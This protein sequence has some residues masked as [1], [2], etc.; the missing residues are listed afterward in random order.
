MKAKW[1]LWMVAVFIAALAL[2]CGCSSKEPAAAKPKAPDARQPVKAADASKPLPK[3]D[4]QTPATK[5]AEPAAKKPET[6]PLETEPPR[7]AVRWVEDKVFEEKDA[8]GRRTKLCIE[9]T[10]NTEKAVKASVIFVFSDQDGNEIKRAPV[11]AE[12]AGSKTTRVDLMLEPGVEPKGN[13]F[14][15]AFVEPAKPQ[16]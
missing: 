6:L 1:I 11:L 14:C 15:K 8:N 7:P 16:P 4:I 5:P 3:P 12:L 9:V 10:N 13:Y 2:A